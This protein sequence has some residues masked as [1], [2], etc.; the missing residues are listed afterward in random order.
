LKGQAA[1]F[2]SVQEKQGPKLKKMSENQAFSQGKLAEKL[3]IGMIPRESF[4]ER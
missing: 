1:K 4:V 3:L 2:Y